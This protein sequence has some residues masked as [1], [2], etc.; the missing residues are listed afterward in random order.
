MHEDLA[1]TSALHEDPVQCGRVRTHKEAVRS[2]LAQGSA[3]HEG[4]NCVTALCKDEVR[5]RAL[6]KDLA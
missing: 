3:F 2:G 6:H 1:R 5:V 4:L